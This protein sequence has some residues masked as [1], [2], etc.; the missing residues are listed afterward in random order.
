VLAIRSAGFVTDATASY[1]RLGY[2]RAPQFDSTA[3]VRSVAHLRYL[4]QM[5]LNLVR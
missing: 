3:P 1:E 2:R 5:Y 4:A